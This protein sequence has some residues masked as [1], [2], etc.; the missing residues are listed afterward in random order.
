M[1]IGVQYDKSCSKLDYYAM[2]QS[3]PRLGLIDTLYFVDIRCG[4]EVCF[5]QWNVNENDNVQVQPR[6]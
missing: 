3:R 4:Q 1:N 5:G 2:T 6:P